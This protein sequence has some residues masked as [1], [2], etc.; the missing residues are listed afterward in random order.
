MSKQETFG[1]RLRKFAI[2]KFGSI[3]KLVEISGIAQPLLS[4]YI[5]NKK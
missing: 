4:K 5:N 2:E 3:N 1:D